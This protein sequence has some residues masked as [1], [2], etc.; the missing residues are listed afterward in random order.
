MLLH[1]D[2]ADKAREQ[3]RRLLASETLRN[4]DTLRRLFAYLADK[5]LTGQAGTLKEYV[6]GM[7]VFNKPQDYDPQKDASVRIQ[8]GK[9]RQKIEEYY[10]KE[11]VGDPVLIDLPKGHFELR[12][13]PNRSRPG[14]AVELRRWKMAA[15]AVAFAWL[16]TS[17][18]LLLNGRA[19]RPEPLSPAQRALWAPL[20][21]GERQVLV[22]VGTPLFIKSPRGFFRSPR[23]N[24]WEEAAGAPDVDWMRSDIEADRAGPVY[25]YT[26]VGDAMGAADVARLLTAAGARFAI[27]RS[28]TL[29]WEEQSQNHMVFLG[30]PK[31]AARI[32]ELPMSM[33]L[34]MEGSR[35]RNLRPQP[36][37][38]EWLQGQWPDNSPYVLEDY[39]LISR[40]PG[41]HGRA[42]YLILSAS[43]TEGTAAAAQFVTDPKFAAELFHRVSGGAARLPDYFQAVIHARFKAMV[44]VEMS[45][46][47]H[48]VLQMQSEPATRK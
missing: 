25:I 1:A 17:A 3:V 2:S 35:I 24:R 20:L 39:A 33:E 40:V 36:G 5:S 22:C 43:S 44:P 38:P 30:P 13:S 14:A 29:G 41:L 28:S 27:R 31:Y 9:L 23:V 7:E 18:V 16:V 11:G 47:F 26:G 37:E 12:F 19:A 8:V 48:H 32:S 45:Y 6:V 10:R 21:D 42:T 46:R 34:V 4:A 15:G